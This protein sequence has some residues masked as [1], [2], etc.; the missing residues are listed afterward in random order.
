MSDECIEAS[1]WMSSG[2]LQGSTRLQYNAFPSSIC[3]TQDFHR[4]NAVHALPWP[5]Y[6]PSSTPSRIDEGPHWLTD[7][8]TWPTTRNHGTIMPGNSGSMGWH[9]TG[10]NYSFEPIHAM[11]TKRSTWD[12]WFVTTIID[13]A[14]LNS[15]LH[16]AKCH[17]KLLFDKW[18]LKTNS[19]FKPSNFFGNFHNPL[20]SCWIFCAFHF[21]CSLYPLE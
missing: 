15:L 7:K 6:S 16:R 10:K 8:V 13:L 1:S 5:A 21:L 2:V 4:P 9:T 11:E 19:W 20:I 3:L 12:T 17:N 14:A 18:W